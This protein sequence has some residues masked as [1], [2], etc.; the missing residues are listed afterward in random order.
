MFSY[1][2]S[3]N[4][5]IESLPEFNSQYIINSVVPVIWLEHCL[6][7]AMPL[8]YSSCKMFEDRGDGR[9]R[10]FNN[11][12]ALYKNLS[13]ATLGA[14]IEFRRWAKLEAVVRT[15]KHVSLE[16]IA[17]D[18][19]LFNSIAGV[20]EKLC[21]Y[22]SWNW[23][24]PS[25]LIENYFD[26][27]FIPKQMKVKKQAESL[28]GLLVIAYNHETSPKTVHFELKQKGVPILHTSITL[29]PGWNETLFECSLPNNDMLSLADLY[30]DNDETA[31]ITFQTLDFVNAGYKL[32]KRPAK[33][34]KCV[35]WDLDNTMWKGVIGD[36]GKNGVQ[37]FEHSMNLVKKLDEMGIIQTVISKNEFGIAWSKLK[38]LGLSEYFLYPAINWNP[39]SQNLQSIANAL[40]INID[41]F[42]VIDDSLFERQ[43]IKKMLPQ[44]RTYD[45]IEVDD[46][47]T[48]PEFDIPITSESKNRRYSYQ[49][50]AQR[51]HILSSWEGDYDSFLKECEINL[52]L[53]VPI[54]E[55]DQHR[56]FELIQRSNQYNVTRDRRS[57]SYINAVVNDSNFRPYSFRV[58]DKFGNYG[59]VGF[60]N[61]EIVENDLYLRDFV[62]SCRV[63]KKSVER[64]FFSHITSLLKDDQTLYIKIEKTDRNNPIRTELKNLGMKVISDTNKEL[65]LSFTKGKT[66]PIVCDT[67]HIQTIN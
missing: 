67:I 59:I 3:N 23:H 32:S 12:T 52:E 1:I 19:R 28:S 60:A 43:E 17:K 8:C 58:S 46:L 63:A 54:N 65:D 30:M 10:R 21:R 61:F 45:V 34:V 42:A 14:T 33:K 64:A 7:C 57:E 55:D 44:V 11:G 56:C 9:C 38:D 4:S 62:M 48:K 2:W 15:S 18:E 39:K 41:T 35:A 16:T 66:V 5:N 36:D 47:L 25:R 26:E 27:V 50:E 53:R 29:K 51:K 22:L 24:R 40:N 37:P 13:S 49:I 6:E 20:V 31:K